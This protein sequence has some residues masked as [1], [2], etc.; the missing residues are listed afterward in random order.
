MIL[1]QIT[2]FSQFLTKVLVKSLKE[3]VQSWWDLQPL[4]EDP[5]L[6][7]KLNSLGPFHKSAQVPLRRQRPTN[8]KLLWALLEQWVHHLLLKY[9]ENSLTN[10]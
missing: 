1:N 7:L 8:P 10:T 5:L 6:P 2:R 4:L 3:L 9:G